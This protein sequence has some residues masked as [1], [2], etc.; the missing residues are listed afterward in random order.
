M[1]TVLDR[2]REI[3]VSL[4]PALVLSPASPLCPRRT[5][6]VETNPLTP[7][8][9]ASAKPLVSEGQS[10]QGALRLR[11]HCSHQV[12]REL[13]VGEEGILR[14]PEAGV[15]RSGPCGR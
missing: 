4:F 13:E 11:H 9:A 6:A 3:L 12:G 1:S 10:G 14:R 15:L 8:V 2:A 5:V 7:L